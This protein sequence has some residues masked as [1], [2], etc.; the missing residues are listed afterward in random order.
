MATLDGNNSG[1]VI[2]VEFSVLGVPTELTLRDLAITQG[3]VNLGAGSINDIG[4]GIFNNHGILRDCQAR[5]PSVRTERR[6]A[7]GS[8]ATVRSS[9]ATASG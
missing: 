3:S 2:L 1:R 8:A 6:T 7:A 5:R 9:W 4:G